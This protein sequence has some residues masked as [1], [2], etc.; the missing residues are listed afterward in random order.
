MR[1]LPDI[2]CKLE[3]LASSA[4]KF[5]EISFILHGTQSCKESNDDYLRIMMTMSKIATKTLL[6]GEAIS[7]QNLAMILYGLRSN[8]F[9]GKGSKEMLSCLPRIV[10]ECKEPFDAQAVGNAFVRLAGH[11]QR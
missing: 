2:A 6:R 11:E 1:R 7:S 8:K 10:E 3:S 9:E 5:K 4:W